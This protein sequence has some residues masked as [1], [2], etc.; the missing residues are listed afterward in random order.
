[1]DHESISITNAVLHHHPNG[2]MVLMGQQ[3]VLQHVLDESGIMQ[4]RLAT[5][6]AC[7]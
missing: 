1:M 7:R 5:P 6:S 3:S 4:N 2:E